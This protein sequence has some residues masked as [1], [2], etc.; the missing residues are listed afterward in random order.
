MKTVTFTIEPFTESLKRFK[1]TFEAVRA[2]RKVEPQEIGGFTSLEAGRNF[3]TA[4]VWLFFG[5]SGP[6]ARAPCT[7]WQSS[8][9]ATSRTSRKTSEF[10]K[11][12]VW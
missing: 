2:G 6:C 9:T 8:S 3:L 10:W 11:G 12:T 5:R 7:N 4:S 1:Q